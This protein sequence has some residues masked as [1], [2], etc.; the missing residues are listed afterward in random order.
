M[1]NGDI[2][3]KKTLFS[4]MIVFFAICLNDTSAVQEGVPERGL[5]IAPAKL[6]L[7]LEPGEIK[8]FDVNV[9]NY[10]KKLTH[11]VVVGIE[12]FY[13]TDGSAKAQF[14]VPEA[15]HELIAYDVIDWIEVE[16]EFELKPGEA[17]NVKVQ[18]TVPK[19]TPTGGYYG[20]VFFKTSESQDNTVDGD[21]AS[22]DVNYRVGMLLIN[23]VHGDA[24]IVIDGSVEE[25]NVTEKIFWQSPVTIFATLRSEG[26]IHYEASGQMEIKKFGKKNK[27][28]MIE[29]EVMFPSRSKTF[30]KQTEFGMWDFGVYGATLDMQS[31][32]GTVIFQDNI[33]T[34]FIIPWKG[35]AVVLSGVIG[36]IIIGKLFKK[37]VH[38]GTNPVKRNNKK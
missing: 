16:K 9:K 35:L 29:P 14:F 33:Q 4:L 37:Y 28:I 24:P 6:T 5:Q 1:I 11:K 13:V 19:N 8:E 36:L 18:V 12:D 3:M 7:D 31:E 34:F 10:D 32:D 26:N 21:S 23:A 22:I 25:F 2:F 20:V 38:I 15:D 17:K 30:T 27:I